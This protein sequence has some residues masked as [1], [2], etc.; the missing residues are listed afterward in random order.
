ME[1]YT[2]WFLG[3]VKQTGSLGTRK[4][5]KTKNAL[6]FCFI[7]PLNFYQSFTLI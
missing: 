3:L 7:F 5:T 2:L 6:H 4:R 1:K